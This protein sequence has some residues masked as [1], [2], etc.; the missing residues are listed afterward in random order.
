MA[1]RSAKEKTVATLGEYGRTVRVF[2]QGD[3]WRVRSRSLKITQSYRGPEAR[4]KA[5]AFAERLARG[6]APATETHPTVGAL[7]QAYTA[8]SDY[9]ELR[10]RSKVLYEDAWKLFLEVVPHHTPA[11]EITVAVLQKVR[12]VLESTPRPRAPSGLA[13]NTVRKAISVVKGV[14]AWAERT[15]FLPRNRVHSFVFKVGKDRRPQVP[16]EYSREEFDRI[17]GV[18]SFDRLSQRT[19]YCVTAVCG[20]Q[21]ARVGAV[22]QLRWEDVDWER[23]LLLWRAESDKMGNEWDQPMRVPTRAVL[24]RL[25]AAVGE[26]RT[27]WVFPARRAGARSETYTAQSYWWALRAAE[28]RAGVTHRPY[29]AAHGFRRRIA[30]DLVEATGSA[31]LAMEA[32]GDRDVKMAQRYVKRRK[33]RTAQAMKALDRDVA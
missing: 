33:G 30:G 6:G 10:T 8:G 23:D 7:W 18:M 21:G 11:E 32:I 31:Q 20:Y 12:T 29:R 24:A 26:P 3:L 17:I 2:R 14:F 1:K 19:P 27:G 22:L 16:D 9:R 5:F 15:E 13:I 28:D 4:A 25:W